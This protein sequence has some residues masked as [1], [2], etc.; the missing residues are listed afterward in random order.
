MDATDI[1]IISE[2]NDGRISFKTIA[3]KLGLAEGTVRSRVKKLR[4]NG[5]LD[6][7]GLVDPEALDDHSVVIIG[8]RVKDM[9][10]LKKG[11]EFSRLPRVISVSVVTGRFDLIVTVLLEKD[12]GMLEF[13][14]EEAS[15]IDNIQSVET[16]VVYKS[17]N[18]KVP[19][20]VMGQGT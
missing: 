3:D 12:F 13:Y 17:F 8:V 19:L 11:E 16:F 20:A 4:S 5:Q 14:T 15:R 7:T 1:S 10:L 6:I 9:D 18:M 2:L